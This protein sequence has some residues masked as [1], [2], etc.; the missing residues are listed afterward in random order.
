MKTLVRKLS[1]SRRGSKP[2]TPRGVIV[3][4]RRRRR[5]ARPKA[6]ATPRGASSSAPAPP[7]DAGAL[8]RL[9]SV[10]QLNLLLLLCERVERAADADGGRQ[11]A[12]PFA[13]A[14]LPPEAAAVVFLGVAA[15]EERERGALRQLLYGGSVQRLS[16]RLCLVVLS[17]LVA[18]LDPPLL[19]DPIVD[20]LCDVAHSLA[21]SVAV[22]DAA[23][24][25]VAFLRALSDALAPP[26]LRLLRRLCA[27]FDLLASSGMPGL[28]CAEINHQ[29]LPA[30][31][32]PAALV[33]L[34]LDEASE[35]A[36]AA[37]AAVARRDGAGGAGSFADR[38]G[39]RAAELAA[40]ARA[41]ARAQRHTAWLVAVQSREPGVA[42]AR[43]RRARRRL[44]RRRR[45]RRRRRHC[46]RQCRRRCASSA[47]AAAARA[48]AA[49]CASPRARP[50][51]RR[52]CAISATR[53]SPTR[54]CRSTFIE[55]AFRA[56]VLALRLPDGG[57][58]AEGAGG[59]DAAV[60]AELQ[61]LFARLALSTR[62]AVD[63]SALLRALLPPKRRPS[64]GFGGG[65][66]PG[67]E[68]DVS[69]FGKL[70]LERLEKPCPRVRELTSTAS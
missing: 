6:P 48:A 25:C 1:F 60:A 19:P 63:P 61:H 30:L 39:D 13:E 66:A 57:G 22:D 15:K 8:L 62:A 14:V 53:A 38:R 17:Q 36:A 33:L 10:E 55:P 12:M 2:A 27:L 67:A 65:F 11:L 32:E 59:A 51:C 47:T 69:E 16:A 58:A 26:E 50:A 20:E 21:T 43:I 56:F 70:L 68:A 24:S 5:R 23:E 42:P 37:D 3:V 29:F 44:T 4:V 49:H 18:R 7:P 35:E 28:S 31:G 52:A 64:F 34:L 46:R 41:S 40:E 9:A 45:R 54:C